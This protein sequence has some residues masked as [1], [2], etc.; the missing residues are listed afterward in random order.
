MTLLIY[1][2][3]PHSQGAKA[4]AQELGIKR[5]KHH[6]SRWKPK[7]GDTVINWGAVSCPSFAPARVVNKGQDVAVVSDKLKFFKAMAATAIENMMITPPFH[8]TKE[9]AA[10]YLQVN[11][12]KMVCRTILNG[13]GG[14]GIVIATEA[15]QLV[16]AP[17]YVRY[18]NKKD[19]YRV[20][21]FN[22]PD[23]HADPSYGS[24][25]VQHVI[26]TQKKARR[27][28]VPNPNWQIR[29]HA[30]GFIYKRHNVDV[31]TC[32]I[33]VAKKCMSNLALTF[34]AVDVI[35]NEKENRA[36]VLEV[37]S[38]P[39]LEGQTVKNYAKAIRELL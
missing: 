23:Q 9:A 24:F 8:V 18:V 13:S 7:A 6:G 27:L 33:E 15:S 28:D 32:V 31:P 29:N 12:G 10:A 30:N 36:Y 3:N 14:A 19:E 16:D 17:L 2:G 34:G 4:L 39:G 22:V 38:A 5:I 37:N 21:I 35:Y 20:H 26:D 1:P 25:F 11:G